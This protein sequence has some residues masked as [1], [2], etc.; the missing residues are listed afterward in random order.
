[1]LTLFFTIIFIAEVI[2]ALQVI[3]LINKADCAVIA[4]NSQIETLTLQTK[5]TVIDIRIII[6]KALLKVYDFGEIL[7]KQKNKAKKSIIKNILTTIL[8]LM[9]SSNGKQILTTID[10]VFTAIEFA[11]KLNSFRNA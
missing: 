4:L 5:S 8:F 3:K 9:L 2:I 11:Q 10:L 7:E 6:N 1:M